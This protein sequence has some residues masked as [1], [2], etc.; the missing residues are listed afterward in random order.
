MK[1]IFLLCG[2]FLLFQ[3]QTHVQKTK[4]D[5]EEEGFKGRV[6]TVKSESTSFSVVDGKMVEGKR[7]PARED[8]YDSN[9]YITK[10]E[11][12]GMSRQTIIYGFVDGERTLKFKSTQ[13]GDGPPPAAPPPNPNAKKADPR[14]DIKHRVKR[15]SNGNVIEML[16]IDND[17]SEGNRIVWK[18]DEKGNSIE[19]WLYTSDGKLNS[20]STSSFNDKGYEDKAVAEDP[21]S[22]KT[23][24]SYSYEYD[25]QGNWIKRVESVLTATNDKQSYVPKYVQYRTIKYY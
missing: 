4:T 16:L 17:G 20:R 6:Q 18:Y 1:H 5:W 12:Y 10:S 9:G 2:I 21:N 22:S 7:K 15:D 24:I 8:I 23:Y 14:F 25:S 13:Q 3:T 19:R 11:T